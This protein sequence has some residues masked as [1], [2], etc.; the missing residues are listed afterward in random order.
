MRDCVCVGMREKGSV[1][2]CQNLSVADIRTV[3]DL[4][5]RNRF[6]PGLWLLANLQ[7]YRSVYME[8]HRV[9]PVLMSGDCILAYM[10][11]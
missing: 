11:L 4:S 7:S 5:I 9:A 2:W 8:E 10:L 6:V 3:P 1:T